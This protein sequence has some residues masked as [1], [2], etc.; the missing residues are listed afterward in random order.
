MEVKTEVTGSLR[1]EKRVPQIVK[2]QQDM[3]SGHLANTNILYEKNNMRHPL[4]KAP[5]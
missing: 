3:D 1:R 5:A 4:L 2:F